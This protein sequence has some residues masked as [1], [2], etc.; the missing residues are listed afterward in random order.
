MPEKA[1]EALTLW[2]AFVPQWAFAPLSGEGAARFG[3]RWNPV[4]AATIY[5]AR[6]LSTA[7]AEYNQGFV[8]HPALIAQLDLKDA[9]LADL[10]DL[11]VLSSLAV[12][13]DIHQCEWRM[14]LD[15]GKVPQTHLLR[16]RLLAEGFDGV[17]YPSFMSPGGTC[18]ALWRWNA[19]GA[20]RLD[21]VDPDG[22]LPK[23]PASWV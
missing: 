15:E 8:Q 7:W 21:V 23:T 12:P 19:K 13:E 1:R 5:A 11:D 22:R 10:T 4:G 9:A 17:V 14:L 2:R 6:E 20:P 18:V 16:Q 3:G